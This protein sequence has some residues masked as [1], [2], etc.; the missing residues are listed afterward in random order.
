MGVRY[1]FERE[2]N[3]HLRVVDARKLRRQVSDFL[4]GNLPNEHLPQRFTRRHSRRVNDAVDSGT[5]YLYLFIFFFTSPSTASRNSRG[6][7][8]TE[9]SRSRMR[10]DAK[11]NR[12][13]DAM[14][15]QVEV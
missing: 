10:K 2:K 15:T 4:A 3:R 7:G 11:A 14:T 9:E 5:I 12:S 6:C 1:D 13:F 8:K